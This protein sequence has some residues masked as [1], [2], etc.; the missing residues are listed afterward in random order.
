MK[1]EV[2]MN[3]FLIRGET[4]RCNDG[5][6]LIASGALVEDRGFSSRCPGA[7]YQWRYQQTT[8]VN[9]HQIGI[10]AEGFF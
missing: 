1:T 5:T 10:Q 7:A 6:L 2:E 4:Q 8:F 9:K 3:S